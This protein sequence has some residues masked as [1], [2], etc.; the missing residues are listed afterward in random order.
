MPYA[1][2]TFRVRPG[3]EDELA[4]VFADAPALESPVV[5]DEHGDQTARLLGTGVFVKD[6]VLVRLVHYEGD[7]AGIARHLAAQRHVHV[8]E[9]RIKPYLADPRATGTADG[10][11]AFFRDATM[12]CLTQSTGQTHPTPL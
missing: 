10:F 2:I 1:M 7:F 5:T 6:D 12:R 8:I 4:Q 11:A 9:D 3:H